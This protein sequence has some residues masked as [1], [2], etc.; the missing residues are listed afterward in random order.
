MVMGY[1]SGF[2]EGNAK[3]RI[4]GQE[5]RNMLSDIG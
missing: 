4:L 3:N 1:G 5:G 2:P